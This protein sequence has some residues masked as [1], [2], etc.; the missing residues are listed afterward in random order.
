MKSTAL[1]AVLVLIL[2]P[3]TLL[4]QN[5]YLGNVDTECSTCHGSQLTS[6]L[7]TG[8]ATSFDDIPFL[9]YSCLRC[10]T[11]GWDESVA[12]YGADEYVMEDPNNAFTI[13]DPTN[14]GRVKNVQCENCHGPLGKVD[15]TFLGF[16]EHRAAAVVDLGADNCGAC[17]QGSHH[18]TFSDWQ[19][20]LHAISKATSRNLPFIASNPTCS[21]CHTAEG[22]IQF[23]EQPGLE[24]NVVPP[25]PDGNDLTCAACHV[26]HGTP[27]TANL[28]MS[29]IE[30]CVKCHNPEFDPD[31]PVPEVGQSI[32]HSTAFMFEGI[33]GY[34]FPGF[35]YPSSAHKFVVTDKC[36]ACHVFMIPFDAGPPEVPAYTGHT[37][38]PR[39]EACTPCHED[40]DPA[41]DF[42]YRGVQTEISDL[43]H[44][45]H[46][47]L[48]A[49]TPEE[50]LT[51][52]YLQADFNYQFVH[53]DGS[54]GIH[55]TDYAR[56]LLESSIASFAPVAIDFAFN[57][58]TL[59]LASNGRWV[60]VYLQPPDGY[61]ASDIDVDSIRLKG[62]IPVAMGA[63]T[64][65]CDCDEDGVDELMVKFDRAEVQAS[66]S[67]GKEVTVTVSGLVAGDRFFGTDV[68]RV[69]DAKMS[70]PMA[71]SVLVPGT[72]ATVTW[73]VERRYNTV[74]LLS[75]F[76][77]GA[78][79]NVEARSI[80][81]TGSYLWSVPPVSAD[82]ALLAIVV[83]GME[84][85]SGMELDAELC[86]SDPFSIAAPTDT[87]NRDSF[88]SL[89]GISPNPSSTTFMVRFSLPNSEA[90]LLEIYDVRGR[91]ILARKVGSM[92]PGLHSLDFD[93]GKN[94]PA[95]VY[96]VRL[97]QGGRSHTKQATLLR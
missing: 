5:F 25:G 84:N 6:Y 53:A 79:W 66:V 69:K 44:Q 49:A 23:A 72:Q 8:H 45:L 89:R 13:T 67:A 96:L 39:G 78:S 26:A 22:F 90:A 81:N 97:T 35:S 60:T 94:I 43:T 86:A 37:F 62:S 33:G 95:G 41:E 34:E 57:P 93:W 10:H 7:N 54:D 88:F 58:H 68:I 46:D 9:G 92:G 32:H 56:A 27:N 40:F 64:E 76:D 29:K 1:L 65:I 59:N 15:R 63:P 14:F 30:I 21:G 74:D 70:S 82:V 55:N 83:I 51:D 28:R 38:E 52:T 91:Q 4:G 42:D 71:G 73:P 85:E 24:P 61:A 80:T 75:S 19:G 47:L 18:P 87:R 77:E 2:A 12:N 11:T 50:T 31:N 20:S 16:F 36:V 48:S 3:S 17:H